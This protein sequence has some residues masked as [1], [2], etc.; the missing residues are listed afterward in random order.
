MSSAC[1]AYCP[2]NLKSERDLYFQFIKMYFIK[3]KLFIKMKK[4]II[5]EARAVWCL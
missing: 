2:A 1:A 5:T 3:N 4:I